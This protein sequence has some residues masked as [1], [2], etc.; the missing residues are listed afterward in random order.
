MSNGFLR[1]KCDF[2][3]G[4]R[5][6]VPLL[7]S[8]KTDPVKPLFQAISV[9]VQVKRLVGRISMISLPIAKLLALRGE[10]VP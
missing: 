3:V 4:A 10:V 9:T 8:Q 5:R 1:W 2:R 7:S 6:A